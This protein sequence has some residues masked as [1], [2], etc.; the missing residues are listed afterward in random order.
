[1]K[2]F[3]LAAGRGSRLRPITD[4][5]PKCLV[6]I[7]GRPLLD[8]W[9]HSLAAAGVTE[10]LLNTHH[11]AGQ[12]VAHTRRWN[13]SPTVHVVHEKS[14]LGSAGTLRA[15]RDFVAGEDLFLA[16]NADNLTDYDLRRLVQAHRSHAPVATLTVF[17][18]PQPRECGV[19]ELDGDLVV[20]FEEKPARPRSNLANAGMYVFDPRVLDEL[21]DDR[22]K[23]IG[24]DLLP[25]L[26]GRA[27]A[28]SIGGS[29]FLDIG[30]PAA[31]E[32]ARTDWGGG[33][34]S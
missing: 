12:V 29:Y 6:E 18:A 32:R 9:L 10:V 22:P 14:L 28:V 2:A 3:L 23:D 4:T 26:V 24:F 21:D 1:V 27:R 33:T 5:T 15:N 30:T 19:F 20:G 16:L 31:L 17:A 25:Q 13:A 34:T 8:I 11:L 7:D